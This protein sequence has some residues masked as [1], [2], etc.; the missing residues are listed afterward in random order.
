MIG[1]I[2]SNAIFFMTFRFIYYLCRTLDFSLND[3]ERK[4]KKTLLCVGLL[5]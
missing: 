2:A 5:N 3:L 4:E 1:E